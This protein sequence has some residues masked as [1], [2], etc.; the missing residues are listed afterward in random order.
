MVDLSTAKI[1]DKIK[2]RNG[3]EDEILT[4][5]ELEN[6]SYDFAITTKKAEFLTYLK[7]GHYQ[8]GNFHNLDIVEIIPKKQPKSADAV[9]HPSHYTSGGIECIAAIK[10]SMSSEEYR[11][12]LKGNVIKYIWRYKSKGKPAEDLKKARTYLEWLIKEVGE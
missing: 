12:Y 5:D 9:N 7:D 3:K 10:A 4:I 6:G 1:G 8:Y 11:G 2:F